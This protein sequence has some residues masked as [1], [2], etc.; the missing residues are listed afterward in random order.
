LSLRVCLSN[1]LAGTG[2]RSVLTRAAREPTVYRSLGPQLGL[3]V[4]RCSDDCLGDRGRI[5]AVSF[6]SRRRTNGRT[7]PSFADAA[8]ARI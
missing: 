3:L 1:A 5:I 7:S 4:G 8:A 6:R 2:R